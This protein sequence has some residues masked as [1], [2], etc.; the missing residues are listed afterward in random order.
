[1]LVSVASIIQERLS[2][3]PVVGLCYTVL[4]TVLRCVTQCYTVLHSA[5]QRNTV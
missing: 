5:T 4:C 2:I 1:M 3:E